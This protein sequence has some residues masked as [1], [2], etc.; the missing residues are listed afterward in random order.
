MQSHA[1]KS[2]IRRALGGRGFVMAVIGMAVVIMLS[3]LESAI[4]FIEAGD[5]PNGCHALLFLNAL[6]S[7]TVT[8]AL[9][10]I[11]A[12]PFTS[13]FVDDIKSGFIKQYLHR[14]GIKAY[15]R[16]KLTACGLSG[17][18]ALVLGALG[19]YAILA[20][21]FTPLEL[22]RASDEIAQPYFANLL[23]V[24]A[25]LFFSG[26]LWSLL[27]FTFAAL[28]MS[29][30]IA[31]A[32]PFIIYY[33]LIILH[34]RYFEALYVLYPKEWLFPTNA[35]ALGRLGVLLF[36]IELTAIICLVFV[37]A[38]KRRLENV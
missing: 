17:G 8:L 29:R 34:E 36:L 12:L 23:S 5:L 24:C 35:W 7:N 32:S 30:Y 6:S 4:A 27:G 18:F 3:S 2:D 15:L 10:I 21:V 38:A 19:A 11:C 25:M 26:A 9:P 20:L 13:A 33:V 14:S 16:G 28:T 37:I 22:T 31:Y 1:V